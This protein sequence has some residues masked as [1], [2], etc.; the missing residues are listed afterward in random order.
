ME[1]DFSICWMPKAS[2]LSL[3]S[4]FCLSYFFETSQM[5]AFPQHTRQEL[6]MA[7][8]RPPSVLAGFGNPWQSCSALVKIYHCN[9]TEAIQKSRFPWH[10]TT[11]R[12][13]SSPEVWLCFTDQPY[14]NKALP[15]CCFLVFFSQLPLFPVWLRVFWYQ[16]RGVSLGELSALCP[17]QAAS[18]AS[19]C[20]ATWRGLSVASIELKGLDLASSL[21]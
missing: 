10:Q 20:F 9:C 3:K 17:C 8:C 7:C 18:I 19:S 14:V 6:S 4:W 21:A 13:L 2:Y 5:S 16:D 15:S 1:S 12:L 11:R